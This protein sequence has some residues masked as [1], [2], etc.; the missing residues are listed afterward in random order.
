MCLNNDISQLVYRSA[1]QMMGP[2]VQFLAKNLRDCVNPKHQIHVLQWRRFDSMNGTAA[3]METLTYTGHKINVCV[4]MSNKNRRYYSTLDV[5]TLLKAPITTKITSRASDVTN[6]STGECATNNGSR[7]I[8]SVKTSNS[9]AVASRYNPTVKC[10]S[11]YWRS[12]GMN[13]AS[14]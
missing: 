12:N 3:N 14:Q 6:V 4:S 7:T 8:L 10:R 1:A 5:N 2:H 11:S 13:C 9:G